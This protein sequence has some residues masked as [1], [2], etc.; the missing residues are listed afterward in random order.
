VSLGTMLLLSSDQTRGQKRHDGDVK[1]P[2]R[3]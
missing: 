1:C 2:T 3:G